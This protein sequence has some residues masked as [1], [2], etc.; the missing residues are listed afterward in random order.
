VLS[1]DEIFL[2]NVIMQIMPITRVEKHTVGDGKVGPMVMKLQ[3]SFN[4]FVENECEQHRSS[5]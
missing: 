1:A 2:T 3:R 5:D 4:E